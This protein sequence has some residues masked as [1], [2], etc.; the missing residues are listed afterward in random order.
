MDVIIFIPNTFPILLHK[1]L[2]QGAQN[3]NH[4]TTH[5]KHG[6]CGAYAYA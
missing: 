3:K 6:V 4:H 1:K 5:L 2:G